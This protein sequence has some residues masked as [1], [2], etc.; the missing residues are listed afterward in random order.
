MG[1]MGFWGSE[2]WE[3]SPSKIKALA[4]LSTSYTL[5][6]QAN[7]DTS[8]T[9][10]IN[11]TGKELQ[12]V[13]FS[14]NLYAVAGVSVR[15]EVTH[16]GELVGEKNPLY[17]G[18]DRFGPA[19][20]QL[21]QV[22]VSNVTIDNRGRWLSAQIS[23]SLMEFVPSVKKAYSSGIRSGQGGPVPAGSGGGGKTGSGGGAT[24]SAG[25]GYQVGASDGGPGTASQ[26]TASPYEKAA[27]KAGSGSMG[28]VGSALNKLLGK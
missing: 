7:N 5:K 9:P 10:P 24:T 28:A 8:G 23:I 2:T 12:P 3:I 16:W 15:Q 26:V 27:K 20:M 21:Q 25:G 14:W 19:L 1:I 6:A 11:T 18:G 4:E 22:D 17:I 13:R